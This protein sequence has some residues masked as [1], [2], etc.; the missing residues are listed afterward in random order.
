[1]VKKA[2]SIVVSLLISC[3]GILA[4]PHTAMAAE[5][6]ARPGVSDQVEPQAMPW[7]EA[8]R[9]WTCQ[10]FAEAGISPQQLGDYCAGFVPDEQLNPGAAFIEA[11][12][13]WTCNRVRESHNGVL[14][15]GF[16]EYCDISG[17]ADISGPVIV[18]ATLEVA[19]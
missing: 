12:R 13:Q 3:L 7:L 19:A 11:E 2:F 16:K 4:I 9:Q 15:E 10:R 1:M 6:D 5:S 8:E 17:D 18:D 14:P